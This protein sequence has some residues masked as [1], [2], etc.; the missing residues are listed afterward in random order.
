MQPTMAWLCV[1]SR[2]YTLIQK[3]SWCQDN[4]SRSLTTKVTSVIRQF[5]TSLFL[6]QKSH[7]GKLVEVSTQ[8]CRYLVSS[9]ALI[10]TSACSVMNIYTYTHYSIMRRCSDHSTTPGLI[11]QLTDTAYSPKFRRLSD[12]MGAAP[13]LDGTY[14]Y[15]EHFFI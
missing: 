10:R 12:I 14:Y 4:V 11:M 3:V 1:Y 8:Y 7:G 15:T 13:T 6:L 2:S 5:E 9:L